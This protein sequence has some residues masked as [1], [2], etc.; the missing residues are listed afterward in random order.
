MTAT[1]DEAWE[2]DII[3]GLTALTGD[4][5]PACEIV[6]LDAIVD[7]LFSPSN[8]GSGYGEEHAGQLVSRLF[9]AIDASRRFAP[10]QRPDVTD[11][12]AAARARVVDGAHELAKQGSPGVNLLVSR[13]MPAVLAELEN[14]AEERGKQARGVFVYLL[15]ATSIGTRDTHDQAVLDG[16]SAV[17]TGWDGVLRGGYVLPWRG[18]APEDRPGG[19]GSPEGQGSPGGQG[20]S[21]GQG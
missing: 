18:V 8:P 5:L 15:Y 10:A 3:R 21:E 4:E 20:P 1:S 19:P 2:H 12:I 13:L 16:I 6:L 11:E 17:A 7:W 14:N 9:A